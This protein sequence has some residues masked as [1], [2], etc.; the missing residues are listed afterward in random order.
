MRNDNTTCHHCYGLLSTGGY[1]SSISQVGYSDYDSLEWL[2][3]VRYLCARDAAT[4]TKG[5]RDCRVTPHYTHNVCISLRYFTG[6]MPTHSWPFGSLELCIGSLEFLPP[7]CNIDHTHGHTRDNITMTHGKIAGT[8][9]QSLSCE[10]KGQYIAPEVT[11]NWRWMNKNDFF[12][13]HRRLHP[14]ARE[15][16]RH[17]HWTRH[18]R[19]VHTDIGLTCAGHLAVLTHYV[20]T[21]DKDL[22]AHA[23]S[24]SP[25]SIAGAVPLHG[26]IQNARN[27]TQLVPIHNYTFR[28]C[29]H[30]QVEQPSHT[31]VRHDGQANSYK[32]CFKDCTSGDRRPGLLHTTSG[33]DSMS[34]TA[35]FGRLLSKFCTANRRGVFYSG[36]VLHGTHWLR[37]VRCSRCCKRNSCSHSAVHVQRNCKHRLSH[38]SHV[39]DSVHVFGSPRATPSIMADSKRSRPDYAFTW[40]YE[41][42]PFVKPRK[43][44]T[45]RWFDRYEYIA[46]HR[47]LQGGV[48]AD[49]ASV[50]L[51]SWVRQCLDPDADIGISDQGNLCLRVHHAE[52]PIHM[53]PPKCIPMQMQGVVGAFPLHG[54]LHDARKAAAC[55]PQKDITATGRAQRNATPPRSSAELAATI[56]KPFNSAGPTPKSKEVVHP[57]LQA[58]DGDNM[59]ARPPWSQGERHDVATKSVAAEKAASDKAAT[60]IVHSSGKRG[61]DPVAR[62]TTH[63]Q[64]GHKVLKRTPTQPTTPP[65]PHLLPGYSKADD[66]LPGGIP[67]N[68]ATRQMSPM[69]DTGAASSTG[70]GPNHQEPSAHSSLGQRPKAGK[71]SMQHRRTAVRP[72][73]PPKAAIKRQPGLTPIQ[74]CIAAASRSPNGNDPEDNATTRKLAREFR[75]MCMGGLCGLVAA[76]AP[77]AAI[78]PLAEDPEEYQIAL[79]LGNK[80]QEMDEDATLSTAYKNYGS[81]DGRFC[82][83]LADAMARPGG[84]AMLYEITHA[85]PIYPVDDAETNRQARSLLFLH[86]IGAPISDEALQLNEANRA[87]SAAASNARRVAAAQARVSLSVSPDGHAFM[88]AMNCTLHDMDKDGILVTAYDNYGGLQGGFYRFFN[89]ALVRPG[90]QAGIEAII[91][92]TDRTPH[93]RSLA[94]LQHIGA[95]VSLGAVHANRV[96][97]PSPTESTGSSCS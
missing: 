97:S 72:I 96:R 28:A 13:W 15:A 59:H 31:P 32:D 64:P 54:P 38:Q 11:D 89:D 75:S 86:A 8:G 68:R 10:P 24:L 43:T 92:A 45:W 85:P 22:S 48:N 95:P 60:P 20:G 69:R 25:A 49:D 94:L 36:A 70:P 27:K 91:Q 71:A 87:A 9:N 44:E 61:S 77:A 1:T 41:D 76:P 14:R 82:S 6:M 78:V 30:V 84:F 65:P 26:P 3:T 37:K 80:L 42:D 12:D 58:R 83:F 57:D 46:W 29:D 18:C 74:I 79:G 50:A 17:W 66:S 35:K 73:V 62:C 90:G 51:Q 67:A 81:D 2:T 16:I 52:L 33:E 53:H 34:R 19:D 7:F 5:H 63:M 88:P 39:R 47:R 55:T 23:G 93:A 40:T 21:S 4:V 56:L